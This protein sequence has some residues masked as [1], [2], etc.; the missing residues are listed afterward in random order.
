MPSNPPQTIKVKASMY[1]GEFGKH[2]YITIYGRG[3]KFEYRALNIIDAK[4][5]VERI[6]KEHYPDDR[7]EEIGEIELGFVYPRIGD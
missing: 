1:A 7:I 6:M 2:I 3:V 4:N 5:Y